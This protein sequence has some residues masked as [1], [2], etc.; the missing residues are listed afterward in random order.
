MRNLKGQRG[1]TLVELAVYMV[2]AS[3]AVTLAAHMWSMA[4]VSNADTRKRAEIN[5]DMQDILFFLDDDIG[6]IGAKSYHSNAWI[7]YD[8]WDNAD[9]SA[10]WR[11]N[12]VLRD[13]YWDTTRV[14]PMLAEFRD[15]SSF[16]IVDHDTLDELKFKCLVYDTAG[17][18]FALDSV[19]YSVEPS[20]KLVRRHWRWRFERDSVEYGRKTGSGSPH[21]GSETVAD[22]VYKFNVVAGVYLADSTGDTLLVARNVIRQESTGSPPSTPLV[23]PAIGERHMQFQFAE[24]TRGYGERY[25]F[26]DSTNESSPSLRSGK[27]LVRGHKYRLDFDLSVNTR[28]TMYMNRWA[29]GVA[30]SDDYQPDTLALFLAKSAGAPVGGVDSIYLF[31]ADSNGSVR[32]YSFEFSP[33][34]TVGGNAVQLRFYWALHSNFWE[35]DESV[36]I[37]IGQMPTLSFDNVVVTEISGNAYTQSANPDYGER[38]RTRSLDVTVGVRRPDLWQKGGAS[39]VVKDYRKIIRIPDNGPVR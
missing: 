33:T 3:I 38:E 15:S 24:G 39:Y 22:N 29:P 19:L 16:E 8:G 14:G 13:V 34:E 7:H 32:S 1:F 20:H 10:S 28:M 35:N 31:P 30:Q 17:K 36:V 5:S 4:S 12:R 26:C 2:V 27:Q 23:V 9:D 6:R 18:A 37:N 25:G 21:I 11:S